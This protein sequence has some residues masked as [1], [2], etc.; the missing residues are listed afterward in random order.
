MWTLIRRAL[1]Q[2]L[3]GEGNVQTEENK[4]YFHLKLTTEPALPG[5]IWGHVGTCRGRS[6]TCIVTSLE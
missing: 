4:G 1:G 2:V 5:H 3:S 6:V